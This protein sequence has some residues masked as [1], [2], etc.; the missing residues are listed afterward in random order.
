M[1]EI[2]QYVMALIPTITAV[3]S[4][5]AAVVS[6]LKKAKELFKNTN[7]EVD[8]LKK[9]SQEVLAENAELK[10]AIRLKIDKIAE[11]DDIIDKGV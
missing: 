9:L 7:I 6:M 1:E 3:I 10:K 5:I 2:T 11:L 8:E 4:V